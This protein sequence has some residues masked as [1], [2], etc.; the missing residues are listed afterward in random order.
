MPDEKLAKAIRS[1]TRR[2][3]LLL[4]CQKEKMSVHEIA[5][6]LS[7]SESSASKHLKLLYTFGFFGFSNLANEKFYFLKIKE[8]KKFLEIYNV[9]VRKIR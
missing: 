8:I 6:N 4:L 5:G 1:R 2:K 7:I 3:I 9:V